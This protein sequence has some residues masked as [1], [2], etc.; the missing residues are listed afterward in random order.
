MLNGFVAKQR[1]NEV[2]ESRS[3][4]QRLHQRHVIRKVSPTRDSSNLT[5]P[6]LL[7]S[8]E[9]TPIYSQS[10]IKIYTIYADGHFASKTS[11]AG[12]RVLQVANPP[13]NLPHR[14]LLSLSPTLSLLVSRRPNSQI[15]ATAQLRRLNSRRLDILRRV[16]RRDQPTSFF[17][18]TNARAD[19]PFPTTLFVTSQPTISNRFHEKQKKPDSP[20]PTRYQNSP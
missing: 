20:S 10:L 11:N 12:S 18:Q 7:L 13:P 6:R 9:I 15:Q 14:P 17:K 8:S 5:Y 2:A 1:N 19:V 3:C 16:G 4:C